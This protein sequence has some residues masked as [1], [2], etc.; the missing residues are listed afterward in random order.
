MGALRKELA[1]KDQALQELALKHQLASG[2]AADLQGQV[3]NNAGASAS[4]VN[5]SLS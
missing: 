1:Q 3:D 4:G 2:L 5:S